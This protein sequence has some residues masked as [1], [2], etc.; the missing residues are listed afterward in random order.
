LV[1]GG[2][3]GGAGRLVTG[4]GGAPGR[5]V[6]GG[7]RALGVGGAPVR[8]CIGG[9]GASGG[10]GGAGRAPGG[11]QPGRWRREST[12]RRSRSA[13]VHHGAAFSRMRRR[14]PRV[15]GGIKTLKITGAFTGYR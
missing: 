1:G 12:E 10:G 3:G 11:G 14:P 6:T 4:G 9:G 15:P 7:G 5:L 8:L 2:G 13:G